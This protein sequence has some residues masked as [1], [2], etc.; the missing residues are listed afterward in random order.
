MQTRLLVREGAPIRKNLKCLKII[1]N[2]EK[3]E[4]FSDSDG[5]LIPGQIDR[6]A[7]GPKITLTLTLA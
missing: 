2:E 6:L 4:M 5:G 1:F 7:V 3:E